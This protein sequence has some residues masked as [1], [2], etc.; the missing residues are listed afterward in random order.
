MISPIEND[1]ALLRAL[2]ARELD[3]IN[4]Y[5]RLAAECEDPATIE[6]FTHVVAEEKFHIADA[7]RAVALLD[8][9]QADLLQTGFEAGHGPG[10]VPPAGEGRAIAI[11]ASTI[12]L[13]DGGDMK[14]ADILE[15]EGNGEIRQSRSVQTSD[16]T[17]GTPGQINPDLWK[18][19]PGINAGD[20]ARSGRDSGT[21]KSRVSSTWTV[22]SLRGVPQHE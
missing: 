9:D 6:F 3:T 5:R 10:H 4:S 11:G 21:E 18:V 19:S 12:N 20:S 8:A 15:S 14:A 22:G 1:L 2:V 13:A 17:D 16:A 7:L